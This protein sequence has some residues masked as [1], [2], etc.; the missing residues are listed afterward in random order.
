MMTEENQ[1]LA[2]KRIVLSGGTTGIGRATLLLLA[3]Q[4]ARLLTFGRHQEDLDE[5]LRQ[6]GLDDTAGIT[7]DVSTRDGVQSVFATA[8]DRIGGLDVLIC[9]A[10]LGADPLHEMDDDGWRYVIDTNLVGYLACA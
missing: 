8:D 2:G 7:A 9:N 4:G 1:R 10:A 6:A 5:A 3:R